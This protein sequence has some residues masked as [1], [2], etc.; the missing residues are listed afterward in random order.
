MPLVVARP[1]QENGNGGH[2]YFGPDYLGQH[3]APPIQP[4]NEIVAQIVPHQAIVLLPE[5]P[6]YPLE[7]TLRDPTNQP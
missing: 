7:L 1:L 3:V 4:G 6:D 5:E 2:V